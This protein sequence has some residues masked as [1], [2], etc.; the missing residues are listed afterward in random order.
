MMLFSIE[1]RG[2]LLYCRDEPISGIR[3]YAWQ[4]LDGGGVWQGTREEAE[5]LIVAH[6][7]MT[8]GAQV[9][10]CEHEAAQHL[11]A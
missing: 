1:Y 8:R 11:G 5:A 10:E 3:R 6:G 4:A 9:V 7:Q 2:A